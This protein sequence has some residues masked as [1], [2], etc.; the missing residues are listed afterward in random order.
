MRE[1]AAECDALKAELARCKQQ[2]T[3]DRARMSREHK[4]DCEKL[5]DRWHDTFEAEREEFEKQ[6]AESYASLEHK[7]VSLTELHARLEVV[8]IMLVCD[9]AGLCL[10]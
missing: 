9:P 4:E 7:Y 1:Q 5:I 3:E 6:Q 8:E 2:A 10:V